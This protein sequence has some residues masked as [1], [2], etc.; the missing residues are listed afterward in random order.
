MFSEQTIL[1]KDSEGKYIPYDTINKELCVLL[2]S[3]E[4]VLDRLK[5][6]IDE[7]YQI[8]AEQFINKNTLIVKVNNKYILSD[9]NGNTIGDLVDDFIIPDYKR[10]DSDLIGYEINGKYGFMNILTGERIETDWERVG[11][12]SEG[13][14]P[15]MDPITHK[16]GYINEKME[17]VIECKFDIANSFSNSRASVA[18]KIEKVEDLYNSEIKLDADGKR[19][20]KQMWIKNNLTTYLYGYIDKDGDLAIPYSYFYAGDFHEDMALTKTYTERRAHDFGGAFINKE[21]ERSSYLEATPSNYHSGLAIMRVDGG[22][23]GLDR[24][25]TIDKSF[26][27]KEISIDEYFILDRRQHKSK[28][29]KLHQEDYIIKFVGSYKSRKKLVNDKTVVEIDVYSHIKNKID[30]FY[31]NNV[32]DEKIYAYNNTSNEIILLSDFVVGCRN[33]LTEEEIKPYIRKKTK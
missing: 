2:G 28:F 4:E 29:D 17:L 19:L 16:W 23:Y 25:Y 15:V 3:K 24:Y 13:L 26:E 7:F 8:D 30:D 11:A 6:T 5:K 10:I 33:I 18:K 14:A 22:H 1:F 32:S 9:L 12:F 31:S 20:V 27:I 21:N